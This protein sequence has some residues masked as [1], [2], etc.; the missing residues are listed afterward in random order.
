MGQGEANVHSPRQDDQDE[1]AEDELELDQAPPHHPFHVVAPPLELLRPR[2]Q[3]LALVLHRVH[4]L[5]VVQHLVDVPLHHRLDVAVQV[6]WKA[7]LKT[8]LP[9][10]HLIGSRVETRRFQAQD[11]L[12][13]ACTA[14]P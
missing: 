10:D 4:R 14:P 2:A 12:D 11:K 13:A 7:N 5:R 3:L 1:R 8:R 6:E 9:G